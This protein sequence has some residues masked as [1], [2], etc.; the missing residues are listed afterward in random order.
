MSQ[1][2]PVVR[3][4]SQTPPVD[5]P[6]GNVQRVVTG[7]LGGIANV[8]LVRVTA[9]SP[10]RHTG[11][12]ETY[13]VLSGAGSITLGQAVHRLEPGAVAVIP[14]GLVHSLQADPGQTLEFI[15]FGTPAMSMDAPACAPRKPPSDHL[16]ISS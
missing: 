9:G 4:R 5:C 13:Y 16:P 2:Q 8:H 3:Y 1:I 12:D 11:Y 14:R 6:Y 7:G 10:H 15:I